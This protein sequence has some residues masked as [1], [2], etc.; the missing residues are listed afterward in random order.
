MLLVAGVVV[1]CGVVIVV[2][3]FSPPVAVAARVMLPLPLLLLL[4]LL[5]VFAGDNWR[6]HR[7]QN[8]LMYP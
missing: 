7:P 8:R 2:C 4:L 1:V 3:R 6:Q 5:Q